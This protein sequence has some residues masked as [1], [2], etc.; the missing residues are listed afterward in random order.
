MQRWCLVVLA[1]VASSW[2]AQAEPW[3]PAAGPLMTRWGKQVKPDAVWAEYPRPQMVRRD[4][5][6]LNGLW[7]FDVAQTDEAPPLGKRLAEQILVPFPI[8]SALSGVMRSA[9]RAWYRR[10]FAVP[11]A[12]SG[13]RVLLHFGAVDW[14]STVWV[15]GRKLG[16]HRGG[17]DPFDF[18][19]SDALRPT[20]P[21]ELIVGVF[22][23]SD[24]G[25]QPRGKQVRKPHSIW[26]TSTT[27]IWQTA[28]IE[29]VPA[30]HVT[31]LRI[32][33]DLKAGKLRVTASGTPK[34]AGRQVEFVA[35]VGD[36]RVAMATG[37]VGQT[38]ELTIPKPR[39]WSPADPFLYGLTVS[40]AGG[41]GKADTLESYFGMRDIVVGKDDKGVQRLLLNGRPVF[42]FGPLDQGFWPDGLYTAPS[43]EAQRYDLEVTRRLGFNMV[44]KH[45]KVE[46]DRWYYWCDKLGL[47]VWQDMPSGDR[48]VDSGKGEIQ[49]TADSARQFETELDRLVETHA[50]HPSIVMWVVFNEGWGQYDTVRLAEHVKQLDP[51]RLVCGA[52]GWNDMPAGDVHDIHKY[53]GPATPMPEERRAAVLGEFGGLGLPLVGHTWQSEKNWGYRNLKSLD[54]LND[55]YRKLLDAL[56]PLIAERGLSAAVYTQTTDVEI[57]VNGLM[58][59]DREVIK[60]KPET[61][62]AA[63]KLEE[64]RP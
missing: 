21:Q 28:W 48:S 41:D 43:D 45:V 8:E 37:A 22:D 6:N 52:S 4:W 11:Q 44:R 5:Q 38:I 46:P 9:E 31:A 56:Q 51:S 54:E 58:T 60:L 29:P 2:S 24:A 39:A 32:V 23:P 14:E 57:E 35:T 33:P 64:P 63:E 20:G 42:Q 26:Y 59:Y 25:T 3:K 34:A 7:E 15:N 1:V 27:G 53:P 40:L 18:D 55:G 12:W 19:I 47:L 49:R 17:Y 61:A 30:A 50:N 36:Q 10:T 62:R 16:T 13:Q